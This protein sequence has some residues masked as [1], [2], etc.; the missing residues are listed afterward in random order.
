MDQTLSETDERTPLVCI[1]STG[2]DPTVEIEA[3]A[4]SKGL[5]VRVASMG[6]GQEN[7]ARQLITESC[8]N[9]SW[10]L[11][12]N[13]HLCL[14]FCE[15]IM[16]LL[17]ESNTINPNFRLWLTTE[18]HPQF[19]IGLLH[20]SIKFTNE[21]PQGIRSSMKR[22]YQGITQDSLDYT[23]SKHWPVL[24]YTVAFLHTVV[25]ERRKFGALGWNVAYEFNKA[26]YTASVQFI[27]NHLEE[28][29][30]RKVTN[31]LRIPIRYP[32]LIRHLLNV[33]FPYHYL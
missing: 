24:L 27:Q 19:P 30:P 32:L 29:N 7:Y 8:A 9:G 6:Q 20:A 23:S 16:E 1:L 28:L 11:L 26:D 15:E 25:Q 18:G 12:Q 22:T 14:P 13:C 21:A 4:K 10:T 3:L 2:S 5:L 33:I 31:L 17:S